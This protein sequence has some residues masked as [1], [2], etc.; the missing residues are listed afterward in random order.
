MNNQ[1]KTY[2][3]KLK[4]KPPTTK[5]YLESFERKIGIQLPIE[6]REF[7]LY[8]DGAEGM[9]GNSYLFIWSIRETMEIN[10]L[11]AEDKTM[12][13]N[14]ESPPVI[15]FGSDGSDTTYAFDKRTKDSSIITFPLISIISE[16][17]KLC[18]NTFNEFLHNLYLGL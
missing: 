12:C 16:E 17:Y 9:V 13:L 7:M 18:G 14:S 2:I 10:L 11:S 6:Y 5:E 1:I 8:S 4:L 3:E 15:C